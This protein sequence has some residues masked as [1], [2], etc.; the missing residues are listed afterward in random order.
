MS[1]QKEGSDHARGRPGVERQISEGAGRS[2]TPRSAR[3][4]RGRGWA[5]KARAIGRRQ[6]EVA[7]FRLRAAAP[8]EGAARLRREV[9]AWGKG[10]LRSGSSLRSALPGSG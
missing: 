10:T 1:G 8:P 7:D 4:S 2:A 6:A 5:L 3:G 9:R